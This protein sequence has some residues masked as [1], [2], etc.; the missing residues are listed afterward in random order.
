[1][2][3]WSGTHDML[4]FVS[5]NALWCRKYIKVKIACSTI[6]SLFKTSLIAAVSLNTSGWLDS[7]VMQDKHRWEQWFFSAWSRMWSTLQSADNPVL[8]ILKKMIF[9]SNWQ[10]IST[11]QHKVPLKHPAVKWSPLYTLG[12]LVLAKWDS[13]WKTITWRRV[14]FTCEN[15]II[16]SFSQ[17]PLSVTVFF[18]FILHLI[19]S[20]E[21]SY[22]MRLRRQN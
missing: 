20:R 15:G 5:S 12:V 7:L 10:Y 6:Y 4:S 18:L 13:F 17:M 21:Y 16:K 2:L 1:M 11:H 14:L 19:F 22:S 8:S 9:Y 3:R